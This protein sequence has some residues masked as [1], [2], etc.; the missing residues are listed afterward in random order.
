VL[1]L[2][3]DHT[4][5]YSFWE[6]LEEARKGIIR[7]VLYVVAGAT[8]GWLARTYIFKLLEWPALMGARWAGVPD[9]KFRIF[10]PVAGLFLM[11]TASFIV[12]LVLAAPLWLW[13][14]VRFVNPGLTPRERRLT[15][16]FIPGFIG[17]F[18]AGVVFCYFLAPAFCWFLLRFNRTSFDVAAE[19]TLGSYLRFLMQCLVATGILFE[20]PIVIMFMVWLG[21]TSSQALR[22]KW[23]GAVI[24]ILVIVAVVSPTTDPF[25]MIVMSA[26]L[27]GLFF[28]SLVLAKRVERWKAASAAEDEQDTKDDPYGLQGGAEGLGEPHQKVRAKADR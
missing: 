3:Q 12:G 8:L 18:L 22:E 10:E 26:P 16:W 1:L 20:L 5:E 25:T 13:E 11:M 27:I 17:L 19:W 14:V 6:H 28:A 15:Y 9:F 2:S 4:A 24:I 21:L 7:S 23:R